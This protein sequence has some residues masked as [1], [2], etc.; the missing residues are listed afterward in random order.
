MSSANSSAQPLLDGDSD[1]YNRFPNIYGL[2]V[3]SAGLR[4]DSNSIHRNKI[5]IEGE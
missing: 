4:L 3:G 1:D 5:P 2:P